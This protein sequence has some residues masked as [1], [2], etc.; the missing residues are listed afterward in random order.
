MSQLLPQ[1]DL[2]N[3]SA[4]LKWRDQKLNQYP[5]AIEEL[6]VEVKNPLQLSKNEYLAMQQCIQKTNMVIFAGSTGDDPD[7]EIPRAMG[8]QFGLVK[9]DNNTGADNDGITSLEVKSSTWHK[10]YIPYTNRQIHWHTDGYYNK[11][12]QQI[13]G[14][15]LH[16]VHPASEG[17]ENALMDHEI[18]YIL[19]RDQN[20]DFI[21][22]LMDENAMTIPENKQDDEII[23]PDRSGPVFM[24]GPNGNLHMRYTARKRNVI[25]LQNDLMQQALDALDKILNTSSNYIFRGTLQSGQGFISNNVLHDRSAFNDNE[26]TPRLLYRLRYFDRI[27]G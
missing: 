2:S 17:G 27:K 19:L 16:C 9:L 13:Y 14:L 12:S 1:F 4:Y 23:R 11:L 18:A 21:K 3:P 22:V 26:A 24:A 25:W 5:S 7:K 6:I 8:A 15:Q 20:P 10:H